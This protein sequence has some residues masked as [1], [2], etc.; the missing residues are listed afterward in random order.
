MIGKAD[1]P[2]GANLHLARRRDQPSGTIS[3]SPDAKS[4]PRVISPPR[5]TLSL[6]SGKFSASPELGL[7]HL[8]RRDSHGQPLH[9]LWHTSRDGSSNTSGRLPPRTSRALTSTNAVRNHDVT[10]RKDDDAPRKQ[11]FYPYRSA[12]TTTTIWASPALGAR[13]YGQPLVLGL[14]S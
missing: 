8:H 14:D 5:P 2:S 4:S 9:R 12:V 7:G 6:A 3:A 1:R 11:A 10:P 13:A